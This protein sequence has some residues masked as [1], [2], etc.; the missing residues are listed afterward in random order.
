MCQQNT[1]ST[2]K[3]HAVLGLVGDSDLMLNFFAGTVLGQVINHE[4]KVSR[5]FACYPTKK[6]TAA[7]PDLRTKP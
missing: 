1:R 6:T 2:A 7:P 3:L 5:H 4:L